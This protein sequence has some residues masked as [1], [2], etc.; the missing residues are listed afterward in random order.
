[1]R[2]RE[3]NYP[4]TQKQKEWTT[5]NKTCRAP[6][7]SLKAQICLIF[8]VWISM[9]QD[10][11]YWIAPSSPRLFWSVSIAFPFSQQL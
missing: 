10:E 9:D 11:I 2:H 7:R 3:K 1:M 6:R 8:N 4:K 5:E